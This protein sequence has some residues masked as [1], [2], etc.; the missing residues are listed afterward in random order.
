[1]LTLLYG[2]R[3][4]RNEI[5]KRIADDVESGRRAYLIVPDQKA[6]LSERALMDTLPKSAALLV[7]AVGF[8]RLANLVSR[9]YG[10][11]T[12][13]YATDGAKVLT[14][15]R[16]VK[17]LAPLL[18]I[19]GGETQSSALQS[20]CSLMG[21]FRACSVSTDELS[22]AAEKM[23]DTPLAKKLFDLALIYERYEAILHEKFA[24]QADDIDTLA[25][26]L[27]KHDFFGDAH[28][29][30][31]S[32][33]SFTKQETAVISHILSRGR[34][35]YIALPFSRRGAHMAECADTRK[36]LL[37]LSAKL[38]IKVEE[39]YAEEEA[40]G[41]IEFAKDNLWDFASSDTYDED[42]DGV[43]E[44][45]SCE[46]QNE[47]AEL[48]LR[49]I[50]KALER[51][52]SYSDIAVIARS[53]ENYGGTLDRL[54]T[55]CKIPFFF[56]KKTNADVLPLTKL[57]LSALSLY[58]YNFKESDVAAYIKTGLTGVSDDECDIFEEYIS[59]WNIC[60]RAR[61]LDGE[62]F[63][64]S[65]DGY[66]SEVTDPETLAEVNEI[67]R[68]VTTPL[69]RFC[70]SLDGAK[71][72][73]DF[74]AAVYEYLV[75]MNIRD[76]SCDAEFCKY[77][78]VD[79]SDEAVRLWNVTLEAFDTMVDAAGDEVTTALD[80]CTLTKLL[81]S[82]IDIANIPS[83]KDQV[84]IGGADTI[85]IDERK[86]VIILGAVEGVFP[87]PVKESPTLGE[88]ERNLLKE[89][90]VELSQDLALR[91]ARELYHFA[92][93]I[94]FA[95][96]KAV[97]SYY[98]SN[99]DGEKTE[100]SFAVA[101]LKKIFPKLC[102]YSFGKLPAREKI[103]YPETICDSAGK[104]DAKTEAAFE[105]VMSERGLYI[106]PTKD[107]QKLC[108]ADASLS[109]TL[110]KEI[111]GD[112]L[113]LSQS[114]I[115]R[116]CECHLQHFMQYV[117]S[118][119]NTAPFE[120]DPANLGTFVHSIVENFVSTVNESGKKIG[121]LDED[122]IERLTVSLCAAETEKIMRSSNG[123]SA[124]M[125]CFFER[126]KKNIRLI[127]TN[128]VNEFKNSSFEPFLL[129]Y[130]IG[131]SG[132]H[133]PLVINLGDGATATLGGIADR[134]DIYKNDG[135][136]YIRVADYKSGKKDFREDDLKKGKNLQLLI[137]LFALCNVADKHF[138][139]ALGVDSTDSIIPAGASYFVVNPP[140]IAL[141]SKPDEG[142]AMEMAESSFKRLGFIFD[143]ETLA[144]A[145]DK[146]AQK[147]FSS[148][149]TAKDEDGV[150]ELFD[151][152]KDSIKRVA[153]DMRAGKID[154]SETSMG[155]KSPCRYCA[156]KAVCR[157]ENAKGDG[158][159]NG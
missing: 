51:G 27:A 141:N 3:G 117:L 96:E 89:A 130:K 90:G 26:L 112:N 5:Y 7:D 71:T 53:P 158:A 116:Y 127:L 101:R 102:S 109:A 143:A 39:S 23:G 107:A 88:N 151:T 135:K 98:T 58:V 134:V 36:K 30:V 31:D 32:F 100:P 126:M 110:A 73:R 159:Y 61:Y 115:D 41:A 48:V 21:E 59:R 144:D 113:R 136:V 4:A 75:D 94:D 114:K 154:T 128:L 56:S 74:A 149:L 72:V 132:G 15:Y 99:L 54:L 92:R 145:I 12:Y 57:I 140:K 49:E 40:N 16:T 155:Y 63:T 19:F 34:D 33:L 103:F 2:T 93:S 148:K 45:V 137:Y 83:S 29:Y 10:G 8:S 85:R 13:S 153:C 46:T 142:E 67:K 86:T 20:L 77:F 55:R 87:A 38:S 70:D 44:L 18:N 108:N 152:V 133:K 84:I 129:E 118:L 43:L 81:F 11:L 1:M 157:K 131:L 97:I 139:D 17:E 78:G 47:E 14:M 52:Q 119:E 9:R 150:K 69:A 111:Y 79:K 138:F 80:F 22:A 62:D 76:I 25:E 66:T 60:G 105:K 106:S 104:Y 120:F 91:S 122:E 24:E 35:V 121:E 28:I 147:I 64:M 123:G 68:T 50:F 82:A 95:T 124:R 156:Y 125:L 42:T 6:L 37:S 146:T 65:W